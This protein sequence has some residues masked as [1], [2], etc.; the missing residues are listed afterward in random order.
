MDRSRFF[1]EN[2]EPSFASYLAQTHSTYDKTKLS[3]LNSIFRD[4]VNDLKTHMKECSEDGKAKLD[5][6][7][8][9]FS[10]SAG[11]ILW[12]DVNITKGLA[13]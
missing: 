1:Q 13:A 12:H 7:K 3:A 5:D 4:Y 8:T 10:V 2:E 6:M 9:N 11:S